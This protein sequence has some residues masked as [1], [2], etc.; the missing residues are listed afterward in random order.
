MP[1]TYESDPIIVQSSIYMHDLKM[2]YLV[3]QDA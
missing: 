1:I 3:G 2:I